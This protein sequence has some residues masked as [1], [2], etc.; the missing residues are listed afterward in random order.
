MTY[1]KTIWQDQIRNEQGEIIQNGTPVSANK[2]NK[3]EDQIEL[4]TSQL[5]QNTKKVNDISVFITDFESDVVNGDWMPAIQNALDY[6]FNNGGGTVR[7]PNGIFTIKPTKEIAIKLRNTVNFIGNGY[8]SILKVADD[9]G[10][11]ALCIG[12]IDNGTAHE[13]LSG[14]IVKDFVVDQNGNGNVNCDINHNDGYRKRQHAIE[15]RNYEDCLIENVKVLGC[16]YNQIKMVGSA[17]DSKN[18]TIKKC[19]VYFQRGTTTNPTYDNTAIFVYGDGYE[20]TSNKIETLDPTHGL[21]G[22]ELHGTNGICTNNIIKNY[23]SSIHLQADHIAKH[24]N[25]L[26]SNNIL[27]NCRRGIVL[28]GGNLNTVW[29]SGIKIESNKIFVKLWD[30]ITY[31]SLTEVAG[32]KLVTATILGE[33]RDITISNNEIIFDYNQDTTK[34][35]NTAQSGGVIFNT[36]NANQNPMKNFKITNNL[37]INSP[38][39]GIALVHASDTTKLIENVDISNNTIINCSFNDNSTGVDRGVGIIL[40]G[41]VKGAVI[42]NN[43]VRDTFVTRKILS[44]FYLNSFETGTQQIKWFNNLY[45]DINGNQLPNTINKS[46]VTPN[47]DLILKSSDNKF[48]KLSVASD[49]TLSTTLI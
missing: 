19:K 29:L 40:K 47:N 38:A 41:V 23:D 37:I 16:G 46:F 43:I 35:L 11:Y 27:E 7:I 4:N 39:R 48:Y 30:T 9:T 20:I 45:T 31:T 42:S 49:G 17:Y 26:V 13:R 6:V 25:S 18:G 21:G 2:M 1:E 32:V 10:D 8:K 34:A 24:M 12:H 3:I 15:I 44:A 14:V 5:A 33:Y 36:Y 28:W 22:I